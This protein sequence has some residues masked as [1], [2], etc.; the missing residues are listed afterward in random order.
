MTTQEF[1][2]QLKESGL[3]QESFGA[4]AKILDG[5]QVR[6]TLSDEDKKEIKSILDAESNAANIEAEALEEAASA[7]EEYA[8]GLSAALGDAEEEIG[9]IE[10]DLT[11]E[12][13]EASSS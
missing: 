5:A 12:V 1:K 8:D 7:L 2:E 9:K 6:K 13:D 10:S 4:I 3:S 11:A